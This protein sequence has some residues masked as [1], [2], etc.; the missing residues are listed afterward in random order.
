LK[1]GIPDTLPT[2]FTIQAKD[3]DGNN[4]TKGGD[5]FEVKIQGPKGPVD[6]N[7]KDNQDGTYSVDYQPTDA[8]KH[9]IDVNLKGKPIKDAPFSV[10]VKEGA[11][12]EH[13][14]IES[15]TFTIRAKTKRGEN[16]KDG[17]DNFTVKINGPSGNVPA[18]IKD[19]GDGTYLVSYKLEESGEHK[20]DVMVNGKHIKGSP[21]KQ[22]I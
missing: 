9:K 3:R 16:K 11:D 5:P 13:S 15:F 6:A 10:L 2:N 1:D 14:L 20:I 4:I 12:D 18:N 17:G 8:G 7:I 22:H 21:W 19:I